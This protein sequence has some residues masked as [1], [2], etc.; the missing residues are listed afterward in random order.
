M[1]ESGVKHHNPLKEKG[2]PI[3]RGWQL[4]TCEITKITWQC[5]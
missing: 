3:H 1:V 2:L 4:H 5:N